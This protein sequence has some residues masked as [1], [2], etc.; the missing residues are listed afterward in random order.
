MSP[1]SATADRAL[2]VISNRLPYNLPEKPGSEKPERNVGGLVNALEPALAARQGVWVGWDGVQLDNRKQVDGILHNPRT[3]V[4]DLGVQLVGV[5]LSKCEIQNYYHG[6]ANRTL[7]P[8]FHGLLDKTK[9]VTEY[10]SAYEQVNRRFA[11][12][13]MSMAGPNDQIWIHDYHL[14]LVPGMLRELGFNGRID[15][16][17]HIPF[18]P[19]EIFRAMPWREQVVQGLLATD[20][21]AFHIP[22]YRENFNRTAIDLSSS[23]ITVP[24]LD[25]CSFITHEGGGTVAAALPIGVDVE[26][27]ERLSSRP[28]VI[29]RVGE[30]REAHDGRKI[31]FGA[32]RLDYTKGIKER[33][34]ALERYLEGRPEEIGKVSMIQVVVPS[35]HIVQEYRCLKEE[36]DREVGRINGRFGRGGWV[37]IHYQY[38]SMDRGELAAHY[39]AAR[40]ALI[41]PLKDGMNLVA[42]EFVATRTDDLGVLVLSEFAGVARVLDGALKVNPYDLDSLARA[43]G[44]ALSMPPDQQRPRMMKMRARIRNNTLSRWA[45]RCLNLDIPVRKPAPSVPIQ[46]TAYEYL[47]DM[48]A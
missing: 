25:E 15:F 47:H 28:E 22:G 48:S 43:I 46:S 26:D 16:F 39:M 27:F 1:E 31:L 9:F 6:F 5:P 42:P 10:Y 30:I 4:T 21:I 34:L 14:M 45:D 38:R 13:T 19:S 20:S 35:R 44:E 12:F 18:P 2:M 23:R 37:P 3:F 11:E 24:D 29:R 7:W 41:T 36:I 33:L 40:A 8:L 17:L 32:D